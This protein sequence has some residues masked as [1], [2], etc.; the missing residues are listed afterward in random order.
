MFPFMEKEDTGVS[1]MSWR[2]VQR[3]R[4]IAYLAPALSLTNGRTRP[5]H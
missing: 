5:E 4:L 3:H 1:C 2:N